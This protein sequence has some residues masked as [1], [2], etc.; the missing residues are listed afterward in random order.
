MFSYVILSLDGGEERRCGMH[1]NIRIEYSIIISSY[2]HI[3]G[4]WSRR[5]ERWRLVV[6]TLTGDYLIIVE[7]KI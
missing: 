6:S 2:I 7:Y 3:G 1:A 4:I 5:R